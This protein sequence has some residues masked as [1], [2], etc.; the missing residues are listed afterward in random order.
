MDSRNS[1]TQ[2]WV[3]IVALLVLIG[4]LGAVGLLL[5]GR[6]PGSSRNL[7]LQTFIGGAV[8]Y[9][10]LAGYML[11]YRSDFFRFSPSKIGL[12]LLAAFA[13]LLTGVYF[14]E[15]RQLL[16]LPFDIASWSE[17]FFISDIIKLRTGSHFYLPP[18]D[19]NSSVYTPAAPFLTYFFARLFG[20]PASIAFFRWVQ[21]FYLIGAAI[22]AAC[23]AWLLLRLSVPERFPSISRL[24]LLF[25][26]P[27]SFLFATMAPTSHFNVYLH[28]DPLAL[29]ASTLALWLMLKHAVTRSN[30]W[31]SLMVIMPSLAFLTKQYLAVWAAVYL[32]YLWLDGGYSVRRVVLFAVEC[33]GVL[34]MTL[35]TCL[36]IWGD[37]FRYWVFE[38]MGSHVVS[39]DK[40]SERVADAGWCLALGILGGLVLLR[41]AAL[42]RVLSLWLG[43]IIMVLAAAYT[44]GV[45]Y[46]PTHFG[47]SAMVGYV[48]FLA[49]LVKMWPDGM[50][51]REILAE[52]W[53]QTALVLLLVGTSFAGL[54]FTRL[55]QWPVSP[56]LTRYAHDIEEQF[57]GLPAERVLLDEGDWIYLQ[58]NV[59][60]KDRQPVFVTHRKPHYG[61]LDRIRR[62]DYEKV[63]VHTVGTNVESYDLGED[64]GVQ[65]TLRE[66]Y[67]E[68]G[69]IRHVEGMQSWQFYDLMMGDITVFEPIAPGSASSQVL[70]GSVS[71]GMR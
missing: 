71:G 48:F 54:G 41:G 29:L 58:H 42:R 8:I 13:L 6:L 68:V 19:S 12:S 62:Q 26:I 45:T 65:K 46:S 59:V 53:L 31:L 25:F 56:D 49:A 51:E 37:N 52:D 20:H 61:L 27:A 11:R 2:K 39:L 66:H 60:M 33:F 3:S 32:L 67:R 57:A 5:T 40:M 69:T 63:L 10:A 24:W 28:N 16:A 44:S 43:W 50:P 1:L 64:H 23:S 4:Q 36:I 30:F 34:A 21:Q 55:A 15:I 22:F 18:N 47:P 9:V 7:V 17:P 70:S 14:V 35:A 38:V